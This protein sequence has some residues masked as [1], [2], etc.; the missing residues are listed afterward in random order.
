MRLQWGNPQKYALALVLCVGA[1]FA[2]TVPGVFLWDDQQ[3][4]VDNFYLRDWKHFPSFFTENLVAGAGIQSQLYRPVQLLTHWLDFEVW[5]LDPRGHRLTNLGLHVAGTVLFF[6]AAL[7]L[8]RRMKLPT[9]IS[10]ESAAFLSVLFYATHPLQSGV[11]GYVSGR[12]DLLV[13]LFSACAALSLSG[14]SWLS[15]VFTVLAVFSKENAALLPFFLVAYEKFSNFPQSSWVSSLRKRWIFF[16]IP[17]IYIGLRLSVLNFGGTLN[18]YRTENILTEHYSYRFFTYLST[19][20]QGIWLWVWPL[21]IHHER[22]WSVY[23]EWGHL[24]V[25][26]G[27]I[28]F[29]GFPLLAWSLRKKSP[30]VALGLIWFQWATLPTSNLI[31]LINALIYDHWFLVPGLGWVF[32]GLGVLPRLPPRIAWGTVGAVVLAFSFLTVQYNQVWTAP[33]SLYRHILRFEPDSVKI[34]TNLGMTYDDQGNHEE[35]KRAYA[36]AIELGSP[37]SETY[38][39]LAMTLAQEK[40]WDEALALF[41]KAQTMNE[42]FYAAFEREGD[43]LLI[44]GK[45]ALAIEAY[46]KA[47]RIFPN[48]TT[49]SKLERARRAR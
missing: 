41:R 29:F 1:L 25:A 6:L 44:Q 23:T 49:Q 22:S 16:L 13:V 21:G 38:H 20:A 17:A 42:G 33:Q 28:V 7:K 15:G 18:F 11:V 9:R 3:F 4:I 32:A 10:P 40:K 37:Y 39:N 45:A 43:V 2:N 8:L 46:E 5:G 48:P 34:L 47:L 24:N 26:L 30:L 36:R 35:A 19:L 14:F 31:V 27:G 12:G